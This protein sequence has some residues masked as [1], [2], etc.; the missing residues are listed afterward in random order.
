[1][2]KHRTPSQNGD[3]NYRSERD[4]TSEFR[5]QSNPYRKLDSIPYDKGI[6]PYV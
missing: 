3:F 1:M 2:K 6:L 5:I 4:D